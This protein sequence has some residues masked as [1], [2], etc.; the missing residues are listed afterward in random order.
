[1]L[2]LSCPGQPYLFQP[3]LVFGSDDFF[4]NFAS[5]NEGSSFHLAQFLGTRQ[6]NNAL[7][8]LIIKANRETCS[9]LNLDIFLEKIQNN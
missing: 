1:M 9:G 2:L 8:F 6:K 7:Q 4:L 3:G 5:F